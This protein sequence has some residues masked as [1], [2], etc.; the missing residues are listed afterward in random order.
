VNE[1]YEK[2]IETSV[3]STTFEPVMAREAFPCFD[4]PDKKAIFQLNIFVAEKNMIAISNTEPYQILHTPIG[5]MYSFNETPYMSTY[6]LVWII[7]NFE[8]LETKSSAGTKIR[9][10]T[11]LGRKNEAK[12]ALDLGAKCL[13]FY[14]EYFGI[15]YP[16]E[17]LDLAAIHF[18]HVRAMENWGCINFASHVILPDYKLGLDTVHRAARTICH[19]ISHMWFGNLVT[20]KW[21]TD[22]WLNEGFARYMEHIAVDKFKPNY[23]I[24]QKFYPSVLEDAFRAD[25]ISKTHPVEVPC[26]RA[27]EISK[28]FDLISY[29]K[30]GSII[31]MLNDYLGSEEFIKVIRI[32]LKKYKYSNTE[33]ADLWKTFDENT[34][35][36][37]SLLMEKWTKQP[38]YFLLFSLCKID[39]L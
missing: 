5:K 17:K 6:L 3:L 13:D 28:I 12:F 4:E 36:P 27:C 34:G 11:P 22:I 29:A 31:K 7:G 33:T 25:E 37:I 24:W 18:M 38:G 15:P 1:S 10:Y 19:E 32:Y 20:M 30:G 9:V 35:K 2:Q 21:W 16:L 39:T 14:S 26:G 23:K 8:Y